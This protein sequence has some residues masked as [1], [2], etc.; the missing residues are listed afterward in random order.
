MFV[1]EYVI[2]LREE[3]LMGKQIAEKLSVSVSMVTQYEKENY[4][5]SLE[6]AKKVYKETGI[7]LHPFGEENLKLEVNK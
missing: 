7:A 5:P 1:K 4:N 6:T 3:G 2:K